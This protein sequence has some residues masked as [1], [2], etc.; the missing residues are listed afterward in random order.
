[1]TDLKEK[2]KGKLKEIFQFEN[3]DLDFGIYR[4]INYK[5]KEI[6]KF[7]TKELVDGIQSQLITL[8]KEEI[9]RLKED[10]ENTKLKISKNFGEDAFENG[11]LKEVFKNTPL[12][13]E[14]YERKKQIEQIKLSEDLE[15]EIYNHLINFFS[16]YYENGDFTSK[17]RYGEKEK[18]VI[19]YNG[20][21]VYL[22]WVNKDQYYIKTTDYFRKYTF[23]V[24]NLIVNFKVMKAEEENG[25]AKSQEKK[26]FVL[27]K[28][29]FDFDEKNNKLNIYF[30]YRGL[31]NEEKRRY[32]NGN[33]ISQ[34]KINEEIVNL[35]EEKMPNDKIVKSIFEKKEDKAPIKRHLYN[36]TKRNTTDYF[37][38]KNLKGFLERELD[39]YIKNEFLDLEDLQVLEKSGYFDKLRIY[40]IAVKALRNIALKIIEFLDQIENFQKRLWE[41]KKFVIDTHYVITLDKINEYA[42]EG[43]LDEIL[44]EILSN[45]EQLKEWRELLGVEVKNKNDLIEDNSLQGKEYKKLPIDTKYFDEEFKWKLLV[46]LS[47]ENDLEEILNG[48]LIKSDNFQGLNLLL[49]KYYEKIQTIYIDPPFNTKNIQFLYKDNYLNSSWLSLIYDRLVLSKELLNEKGLLFL[50]LDYNGNFLGRFILNLVFNSDNFINEIIWNYKGTTNS[51]RLFAPKH[52]TIFMYSKSEGYIFNAD[53]VRIP[54]E[55]NEKFEQDDEGKYFQWWKKG[56]KYYPAQK[57]EEDKWILLG[58]YQYDVWNDI[59]SMATAHGKEDFG[60]K[61]Q[62]KEKLLERI[63]K[64]SSDKYNIVLDFFSGIGTTVAT[65][66]KLNRK[67][68]GVEMGEH[69][70]EFYYDKGVKKEGILG[71]MKEVLARFGKHEPCGISKELNWQGGGFFKYHTLE[72]YEDVLENIEF[73]KRQ[74]N[75]LEF[76][77]YFVKYM[78]EWETKKSK[79]FLNINDLK[80]PF[81]FKL[82]ILKDYQQKEVSVDLVETFN[83]LFGLSVK[84]YKSLEENSRRYLF[85]FGEKEG[86]KV[87][88]AWR[89]VK[90]IDFEKDKETI[91][92]GIK[93]FNPDEI[94]I[95]IDAIVEGFKAIES[96]FKSLMF[97]KA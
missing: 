71:R 85:V 14:Y 75:L 39:F 76:Y 93:D 5:K 27:S 73:E 6:E 40:L 23:R 25:N 17:R 72:Q 77:D 24:K 94:Y 18:Y 53:D 2:L 4:I 11:E 78:L 36:Y 37:I 9:D 12:G 10:Y 81:N 35:L 50:H 79:T 41:K 15:R 22:H 56:Q 74:K 46:A 92:K 82:K 68:I 52:E 87:A 90:D 59:P 89:S 67:W 86:K 43:F 30:E 38:H 26:F 45:K 64:A 47:K 7:I 95:N 19:S 51:N 88:I 63:I 55:D 3:E 32:K 96:L 61:T 80:D 84:G 8:S 21:E 65:A 57:F 70:N 29:I 44:D 66:H 58:K 54:Y 34:D 83:Y 97:K 16:R 33:T 48:V 28:R 31:T 20:E 69:F 60:F 1:M 13:R 42:K 49:N 62:K 91:K